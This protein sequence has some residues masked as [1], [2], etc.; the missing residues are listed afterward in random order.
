MKQLA[1]YLSLVKF[2]HTVF[3]LPFAAIG[4]F[5]GMRTMDDHVFD[6]ELAGLVLLC[7]VTARNAAMAFNRWA[8]QDIDRE[9]PRTTEREIPKGV[10][11]SRNALLFVVIN[12][13]VFLVAAYGINFLCFLLAPVALF[14]VLGYSYTKRFS[15]LCHVFLGL[16]LSLAPIGAYLAV[17]G[18]FH[19]LPVLYSVAV[20][21]WVA[22]FD[23][24][25]ALQDIQF[26]QEHRLQSIPA[27]FGV[28]KALWVSSVLHLV[29]AA[30]ILGGAWILYRE[31]GLTYWM[32]AGSF[33][34]VGLLVMQHVI[35]GK[36]DLS[37][38]N[39]AFFTTN[40][41]A[42]ILLATG[43]ILDFYF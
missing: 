23:I 25:Y 10:I 43:T 39:L 35:V 6:L 19:W 42:S 33:C 21:S 24:I 32:M 2:S 22:G 27:K 31:F 28:S 37:K 41:V 29:S 4:F 9:N 12:A 17:T 26:D 8:D 30:S 5:I 13:L 7:M 16:G 38:I 1:S 14:V 20:I 40:G 18:H 11:S 34:F 15:W 3:A 36:G